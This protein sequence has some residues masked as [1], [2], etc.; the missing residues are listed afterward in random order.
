MK[1]FQS[2]IL[3]NILAI[4]TYKKDLYYNVSLTFLS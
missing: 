3:D 1:I 2:R 4:F